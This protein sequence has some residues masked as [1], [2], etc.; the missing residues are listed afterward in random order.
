[1]LISKTTP[2]IGGALVPDLNSVSP[3]YSFKKLSTAGKIVTVLNFFTEPYLMTMF[4]LNKNPFKSNIF[5]N[6][7]VAMGS[8]QF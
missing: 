8:K 6:L 1:M 4:I 7:F 3:N 5:S 2:T